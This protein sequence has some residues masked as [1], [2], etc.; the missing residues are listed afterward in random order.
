MNTQ[1]TVSCTQG[2]QSDWK[3]ETLLKVQD[4]GQMTLEMGIEA[5]SPW[6]SVEGAQAFILGSEGL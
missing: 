6:V 2:A 4:E 1:H 3:W 5:P